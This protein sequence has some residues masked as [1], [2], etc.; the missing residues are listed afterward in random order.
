M[1]PEQQ[2]QAEAQQQHG[3]CRGWQRCRQAGRQQVGG[4]AAAHCCHG[5]DVGHARGGGDQQE[6]GQV[7]AGLALIALQQ[8]HAGG[9][10][11]ACAHQQE[12]V[13]DQIDQQHQP[14][15]SQPVGGARL[16]GSHQ[17][18]TADGGA[19]QQDAG[20]EALAQALQA[21][22]VRTSGGGHGGHEQPTV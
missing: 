16:G 13:L 12:G 20:T 17:V 21:E 9:R 4:Q 15:Q 2:H 22:A 10:R 6:Q 14:H 11:E 5:R 19:G 3:Q 18:R 8:A 1:P 7:P